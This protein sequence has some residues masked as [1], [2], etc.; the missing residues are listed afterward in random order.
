MKKSEA[1]IK[2]NVSADYQGKSNPSTHFDELSG[3]SSGTKKEQV[4][5]SLC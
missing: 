5:I 1:L 2:S 4:K 3:V